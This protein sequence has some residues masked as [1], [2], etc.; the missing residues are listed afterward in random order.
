MILSHIWVTHPDCL[1][2]PRRTG[3]LQGLRRQGEAA[4]RLFPL[5]GWAGV[6]SRIVMNLRWEHRGG[7]V[8]DWRRVECLELHVVPAVSAV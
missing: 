2:T 7:S 5:G 1:C 4:E 6:G 8:V 3:S